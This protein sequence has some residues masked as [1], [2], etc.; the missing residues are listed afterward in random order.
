M[1]SRT[2]STPGGSPPRGRGF[3]DARPPAGHIAQ[4]RTILADTPEH[5]FAVGV[6]LGRAAFPGAALA[7]V[8]DLGAGKTVLA[9]GVGAGLQVT[10]RV[11]SPSFILVQTHH[12]GRLPLWHADL[13]RLGDASELDQLG[14]DELLDADGVVMV[15]WADRFPE[16]L[17]EDHLL[18]RL[19]DLGQARRLELGATG[20]R[21]RPLEGI[22]VP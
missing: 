9:R 19:V 13:Y 3:L 4:V 17:P 10:T 21:H 12:G 7:L 14:L 5:T 16:L 8:G 11:Q 18:V 15:E 6:A 2:C 20:P 1:P 22:D